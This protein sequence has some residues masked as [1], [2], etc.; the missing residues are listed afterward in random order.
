MTGVD[1][2]LRI[3]DS[4]VLQAG[5]SHPVHSQEAG[6]DSTH[7]SAFLT[8]SIDLL[9]LVRSH[10]RVPVQS[11]EEATTSSDSTGGTRRSGADSVACESRADEASFNKTSAGLE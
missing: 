1:G 5:V 7:S 8:E 4:S 10:P 3:C 9:G 11:R 2:T 6:R